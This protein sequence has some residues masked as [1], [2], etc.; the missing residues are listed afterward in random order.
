M[1]Q[2]AGHLPTALWVRTHDR[3]NSQRAGIL[4]TFLGGVAMVIIYLFS[5]RGHVPEGDGHYIWL[6]ARSLVFDGDLDFANDYTL[7]GDPWGVGGAQAANP[8]ANPYSLGPSLFWMPALWLGRW[9]VTSQAGATPAQLAGCGGPLVKFALL[10]G[11]LAGAVTLY[12]CY[13]AAR[14]FAGDGTAAMA[15]AM[16]GLGGSMLA[17]ATEFASYSHVYIALCVAVVVCLAFRAWERPE[18]IGRWVAVAAALAVTTLQ[19]STEAIVVLVPVTVAIIRLWRRWPHLATA[20]VL[21]GLGIT[22][23]AA[24]AHILHKTMYGHYFRPPQGP[25][26]WHLTAAHPFLL[27][28]APHGGLVYTTPAA[29]LSFAGICVCLRRWPHFRSLA[30]ALLAF[31]AASIYLYA[32]PLDWHGTGTFGA[33]RLTGLTV[34][35]ALFAACALERLAAWLRAQPQRALALAGSLAVLPFACS[36]VFAAYAQ[37]SRQLPVIRAPSQA[38]IYGHGSRAAWSLI[39]EYVGP[40]SVLPAALLFRLRYGVPM[41]QFA[42]ATE[43]YWYERNPRDLAWI[44]HWVPVGPVAAPLTRG[45]E[46]SSSNTLAV[47]QPRATFVF[48]AQW[49]FSTHL[50]VSTRATKKT[51]LRVGAGSLFGTQWYGEVDVP[52][53]DKSHE[54]S[55]IAG[56]F[57]SGLNEL[58]FEV[59]DVSANVLLIAL[60]F[61]DRTSYPKP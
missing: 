5:P 50:L 36:T 60:S 9:L 14:R 52:A 45:M 46:A 51:K 54:L 21:L 2:V 18:A 6:F 13:R 25:H 47:K 15:T 30:W 53:G 58:V 56:T 19:H 24:P 22:L 16:L 1:R 7:C 4:M 32:S 3:L 12:V 20:L 42:L 29:W 44:N 10:V 28:F 49:P 57:S 37:G 43:T 59:E 26:H 40:L 17:Y 55:V 35:L 23:G 48:S 39:D 8:G 27:L 38:E 33:R 11:P 31:M 61:D 41:T 34:V